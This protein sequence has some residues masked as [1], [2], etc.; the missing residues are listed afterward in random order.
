MNARPSRVALGLVPLVAGLGVWQL[1]ATSDSPYAPPPSA[2]WQALTQM[3]EAGTLLPAVASTLETVA[4]ALAVAAV[5]GT[6]LGLAIGSVPALQRALGPTMEFWRTMPPPAIV[7]AAALLLGLGRTMAVVVIV[8]AAVW[9]IVLNTVAGV[10]AIHPV[11]L[12]STR[13]LHVPPRTRVL[14]VLGPAVLP[15]VLL[16]LRVATPVCI[17]VTLL[18]EMLTGSAGVGALLLQAE[19]DFLSAQAFAL[20]VVVGL[21]GLAINLVVLSLDRWVMLR[22]PP[23]R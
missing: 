8:L 15:W 14:Q 18:V 2:W 12:E 4:V 5:L 20:L 21:L 3:Q 17:I 11:L 7:P 9:P 19:R 22:R 23:R 16:G 10:R 1:L 13:V 6:A